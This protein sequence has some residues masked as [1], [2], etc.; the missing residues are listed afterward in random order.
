MQITREISLEAGNS[1]LTL[2]LE[3]MNFAARTVRWSVWDVAQMA[4]SRADGSLNDDCW[5]YIPL[6][7]ERENPYTVIFGD[8]NPQYQLD[9]E[10]GMLAVQYKGMV[11]K[12]GAH[13]PAGWLAFA[14]R[15]AGY[16]LC[17]QFEYQPDAEYPDHGS[18]VECWT[19]SPGAPSPIEFLS[20][21]Y[22]LEA[23]TL[24]PLHTLHPYDGASQ[25]IIWSAAKCPG[26]IVDVNDVGC[27]NQ[28]LTLEITEEGAK[29]AGIFGCFVEGKAQLLLL[30]KTDTVIEKMDLGKVSP[31]KTLEI[32]LICGGGEDVSKAQL[33]ILNEANGLAGTLASTTL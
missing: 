14:N 15:A 6:D 10:R 29:V 31:L 2:D 11:G 9:A 17:M 23:E 3:F 26:P 13:S 25:R 24:S 22:I 33:D 20:P 1:R 16:V 12:I 7:A 4:C 28:P 21:G 30:N 32:D 27:V 8:D 19:E 5:L 18:T